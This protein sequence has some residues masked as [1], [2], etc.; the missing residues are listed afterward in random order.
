MHRA[1]ARFPNDLIGAP[2]DDVRLDR[3]REIAGKF[4]DFA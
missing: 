3:L 1:C 2:N 4:Y